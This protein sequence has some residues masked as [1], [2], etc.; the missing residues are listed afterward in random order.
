MRVLLFATCIALAGCQTYDSEPAP[1]PE[2]PRAVATPE[3]LGE[4]PVLVS[5]TCAGCH[6]VEPDT[7]SPVA[8]APTFTDIANSEGLTRETL[9]AYLGDAHNYP[10]QMDVD[11]DEADIEVI[12]DY[13]LSLQTPDY[14]RT[15]S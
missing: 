15:P 7:L 12:A 6:A 14:H 8:D 5:A 4:M 1:E 9:I 10:D 2:R 13:L 11:L 3:T